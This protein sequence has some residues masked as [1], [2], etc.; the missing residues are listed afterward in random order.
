MAFSLDSRLVTDHEEICDFLI[1]GFPGK[2]CR[3]IYEP[4]DLECPNCFLDIDT[5]VSTNIY[6]PGGPI[7][8]TNNTMCPYCQ[9][10]GRLR[11][12]ETENI[13]LRVYFDHRQF[14]KTADTK[15]IVL[16]GD[17]IQIIGYITDLPKIQR[18]KQMVVDTQVEGYKTYMFEPLSAP[19]PWGFMHDRYFYQFWKRS[20]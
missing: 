19:C 6:K 11:T 15:N 12:E 10:L 4:K 7:P 8:F 17:T 18:A 3:L 13:R 2:V 5:G 20:V 9:S 16:D 1:D 14:V